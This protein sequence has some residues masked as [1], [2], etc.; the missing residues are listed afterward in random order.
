MTNQGWKAKPV[1][2]RTLWNTVHEIPG[3]PNT[4]AI[5]G[6]NHRCAV[7]GCA[8]PGTTQRVTR[9]HAYVITYCRA[10]E[11]SAD[12]HFARVSA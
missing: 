6:R 2:E 3:H 9:T 8:A 5:T 1:P 12:T 4:L 11:H 7:R 10:H